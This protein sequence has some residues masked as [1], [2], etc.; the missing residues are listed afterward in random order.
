MVSYLLVENR[1][2]DRHL[3]QSQ[4]KP[5]MMGVSNIASDKWFSSRRRRAIYHGKT[6][7]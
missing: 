4:V 7:A 2:A 5:Q 1:L 3:V 6:L